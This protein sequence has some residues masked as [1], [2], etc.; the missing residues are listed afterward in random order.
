[1]KTQKKKTFK[2]SL[3]DKHGAWCAWCV[4]YSKKDSRI[5]KYPLVPAKQIRDHLL[6]RNLLE[7]PLT[8]T[9]VLGTFPAHQDCH[10]SE[11]VVASLEDVDK[12]I[13]YYLNLCPEGALNHDRLENAARENVNL[14]WPHLIL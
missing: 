1:M 13:K 7:L 4:A 6:S 8:T 3:I 9:S 14:H 11:I 12:E 5:K 10:Q 2:E